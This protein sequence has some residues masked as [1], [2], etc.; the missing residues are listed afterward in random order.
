MVA[1]DTW[2]CQ[3]IAEMIGTLNPTR[4]ACLGAPMMKTVIPMCMMWM[5]CMNWLLF[6]FPAH[7]IVSRLV[8]SMAVG[9]ASKSCGFMSVAQV[10]RSSV[11]LTLPYTDATTAATPRFLTFFALVLAH[12][13]Q[14]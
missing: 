13:W 8:D 6:A 12:L 11:M 4:T 1:I 10:R 7:G 14:Y 5:L 2:A 3:P 9:L